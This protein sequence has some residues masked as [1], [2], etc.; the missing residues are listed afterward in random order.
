MRE[1]LIR[2]Q[3]IFDTCVPRIWERLLKEDDA[4]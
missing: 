3:L 1:E 4:L 2:N